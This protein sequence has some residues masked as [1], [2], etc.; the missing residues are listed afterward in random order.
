MKIFK[1]LPKYAVVGVIL[2]GLVLAVS[3]F[4]DNDKPTAL[5]DVRVPELSALATR[6]ERAFNANCAQC[7]GKNA[8][9][10]DK[11]PA[12]VHQ[13][14]NPGHHGDQAF[15]IAAKQGVRAHH[16]T[17]GNM[18]PLPLV[19]GAQIAAIVKYVRE[20]Q[21]ANGIVTKPHRM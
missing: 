6:G 15:V 20:L 8:A 19:S 10:T 21:A 3:K 12:L 11:G 13:I 9:G 1:Q 2:L 17:F 5:V 4:F 7:H 18:P 16:W 14:Y